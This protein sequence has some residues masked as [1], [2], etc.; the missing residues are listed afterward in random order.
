MAAAAAADVMAFGEVKGSGITLR[1]SATVAEVEIK[2]RRTVV[3]W[4]TA[5]GVCLL[6]A[7]KPHLYREGKH[8]DDIYTIVN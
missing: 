5:G 4:L 8:P 7:A 6:T 3:M 2:P 1:V